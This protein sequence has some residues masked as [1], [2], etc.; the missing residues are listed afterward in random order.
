MRDCP[1]NPGDHNDALCRLSRRLDLS[2]C[3][4]EIVER[5]ARALDDEDYATAV[6]C[7]DPDVEYDTGEKTICGLEAII[8][9]FKEGAARG[10][11]AF[12]SVVF[13]HEIRPETPWDIRFLDILVRNGKRFV[14]D[15]TMRVTLSERGTITKLRLTY[16]PGERERLRAFLDANSPQ[17]HN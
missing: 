4:M 9:S 14:L 17:G 7:L 16:P 10:R 2:A 6:L 1:K 15:H 8:A 3:V 5:F 12:D 11:K 13:L